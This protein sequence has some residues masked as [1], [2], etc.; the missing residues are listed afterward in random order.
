MGDISTQANDVAAVID[1]GL[2]CRRS[3][4][5]FRI[6]TL[7]LKETDSA[8]TSEAMR[9]RHVIM[10]EARYYMHLNDLCSQVF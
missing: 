7:K 3:R 1:W 9:G 8:V 2:N 4:Y 5:M 10:F 6:C